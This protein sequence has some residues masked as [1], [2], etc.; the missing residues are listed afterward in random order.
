MAAD[1]IEQLK[2]LHTHAIDSRNGYEEALHDAEGRGMTPLFRDMISL[3]TTNAEEL[4]DQL[5]RMDRHPDQNGSFMSTIHRT[6]MGIRALFGGLDESVLPGLIDGEKRNL[7]RYDDAL[8]GRDMNA[9]VRAVLERQ[10]LRIE[11]AVVAMR[12]MQAQS[13]GE[14]A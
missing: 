14:A 5:A 4:F 7:S 1:T 13:S 6:I 2:S 8:E 9:D 10:R 12:A 11:T 3:H